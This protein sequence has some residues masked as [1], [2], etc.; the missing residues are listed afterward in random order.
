MNRAYIH[1]RGALEAGIIWLYARIAIGATGA[2]TLSSGKGIASVS[3]SSAG[4]YVVTLEDAY[5]ALLCTTVTAEGTIT[6]DS[7]TVGTT[8]KVRSSDVTNST[9]PTV[10]I[11]AV[12]A[13]GTAADPGDGDTLNVC[14]TLKA[15]SADY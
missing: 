11:Q 3:R 13:D 14:L 10:T 6:D 15:S 7:A 1:S 12:K 8:F 9:T 5:N 2:P 4:R